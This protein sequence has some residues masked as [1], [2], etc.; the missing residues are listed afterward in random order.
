MPDRVLYIPSVIVAIITISMI[1]FF[2]F[3]KIW[4]GDSVFTIILSKLTSNTG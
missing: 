1:F 4:L 2:F 3:N